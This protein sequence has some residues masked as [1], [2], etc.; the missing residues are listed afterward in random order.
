[1]QHK[2]KNMKAM[3]FLM[4]LSV[5]MAFTSSVLAGG[6]T[7]SSGFTFSYKLGTVTNYHAYAV[8]CQVGTTTQPRGTV[9]LGSWWVKDLGKTAASG[10]V[11]CPPP[12][13]PKGTSP[14]VLGI[15]LFANAVDVGGQPYTHPVVD[16]QIFTA[17]WYNGYA[18]IQVIQPVTDT[19]LQL[20]WGPPFSP[21]SWDLSPDVW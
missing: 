15:L 20:Y 21:F 18:S 7:T 3:K 12:V 8:V 16:V 14:S 9:M 11:T 13:T 6:T 19:G 1:M 17:K 10:T 5:M 2:T 4:G